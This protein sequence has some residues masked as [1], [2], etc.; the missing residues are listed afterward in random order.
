ML[1][2][3]EQVAFWIRKGGPLNVFVFFKDIP[4]VGCAQLDRSPDFL[5]TGAP[6]NSQ[7]HMRVLR[8]QTWFA[9]WLEE[10]SESVWP[11]RRKIEAVASTGDFIAG[12]CRPE[13]RLRLRIFSGH[14]DGAE[15]NLRRGH[16]L[17]I[18]CIALDHY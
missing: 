3:A 17:T 13:S 9:A 4:L 12:H 7:I 1:S 14:V 18:A 8:L 6:R 5:F 16:F 2:D 15:G 10:H 11:V